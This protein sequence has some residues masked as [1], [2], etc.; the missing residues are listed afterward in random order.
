MKRMT[1]L[2]IALLCGLPGL[3]RADSIIWLNSEFPPMAMSQGPQ[4]H[5]G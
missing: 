4:A 1:I 5:Q 3:A 2:L